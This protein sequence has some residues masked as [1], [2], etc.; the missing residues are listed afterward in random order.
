MQIQSFPP[1]GR[2]DAQILIL[3]SMPGVASLEAGQYYAHPRN[4]FWRIMGELLGA[5]P[6]LD[7]AVRVERVMARR[8]AVWDVLKS[9]VRWGS[10]DSSIETDSIVPNDF[11]AF[12][13][14]HANIARVYFNGGTA[15]RVFRRYVWAGLGPRVERIAFARLP[16]TSPAHAGRSFE[17]K[18]DA[19]RAAIVASEDHRRTRAG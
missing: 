18:L 15:E 10:L 13:D 3:G 14:A 17:Q 6:E 7:Y 2:A 8:I 1:I 4:V 5:G 12:F 11:A 9:C 19:W 16:S